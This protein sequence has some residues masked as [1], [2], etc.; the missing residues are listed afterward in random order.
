MCA[1]IIKDLVTDIHNELLEQRRAKSLQAGHDMRL[2]I[3]SF[4][5]SEEEIPSHRGQPELL[6][7]KTHFEKPVLARLADYYTEYAKDYLKGDY[8]MIAYTQ[9]V[10]EILAFEEEFAKD[11]LNGNSIIEIA[12]TCQACLVEAHLDKFYPTFER[13]LQDEHSSRNDG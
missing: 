7:Y 11:F 3:H 12:E 6:F 5:D 4:L 8:S 10:Q 1:R 9:R 2:T 13:L